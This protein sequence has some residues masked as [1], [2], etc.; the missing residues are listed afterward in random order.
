MITILN[1]KVDSMEKEQHKM[2]SLGAT[3]LV[4]FRMYR[5]LELNNTKR[6]LLSTVGRLFASPKIL[7]AE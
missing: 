4:R 6:G 1:L 3:A 7:G 5:N 2:H